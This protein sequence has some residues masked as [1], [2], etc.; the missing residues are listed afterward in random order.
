[1]GFQNVINLC[2]LTYISVSRSSSTNWS[3]S[4]TPAKL[5]FDRDKF[6]AILHPPDRLFNTSLAVIFKAEIN[7]S[8]QSW[9]ETTISI[10]W[11]ISWSVEFC[12]SLNPRVDLLWNHKAEL[13]FCHYSYNRCAFQ[14]YPHMMSQNALLINSNYWVTFEA[15]LKVHVINA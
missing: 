7:T 2:C 5:I 13:S 8:I 15:N 1:M 9:F 3:N 10:L 12:I 11:T 4:S 14:F 6:R